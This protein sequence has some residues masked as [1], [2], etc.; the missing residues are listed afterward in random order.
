MVRLTL[1]TNTAFKHK[2]AFLPGKLFLPLVL[3][4]LEA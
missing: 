3:L 4:L 1:F 2:A